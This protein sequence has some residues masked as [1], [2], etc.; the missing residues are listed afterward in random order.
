MIYAFYINM[1]NLSAQN[2]LKKEYEELICNP[3]PGIQCEPV[4]ENSLLH[5]WAIITGPSDSPFEGGSFILD[6]IFPQDYPFKPPIVKFKTRVYHPNINKEGE[7]SIDILENKW[8]VHYFL[9]KC[10]LNHYIVLLAIQSFL[11][12]PNPD[13]CLVPEIGQI[14]KADR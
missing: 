7:I 3:L 10:I 5:W 14:Y 12:D 4:V 2:R 6:I 13:N 1:I 8:V 11:N 9:D